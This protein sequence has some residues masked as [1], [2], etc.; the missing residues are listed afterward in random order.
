MYKI[1]TNIKY[2][3]YSQDI[4]ICLVAPD[5]PHCL[6]HFVTY[7]L[8]LAHHL[9]PQLAPLLGGGAALGHPFHIALLLKR[10]RALIH[11]LLAA[12]PLLAHSLVESLAACQVPALLLL[13]L[14]ALLLLYSDT[15]H[16]GFRSTNLFVFTNIN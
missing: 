4:F 5:L 6:R 9:A 10:L 8:C 11:K 15:L 3:I 7:W 1:F 13:H 16:S 14:L 2:R 12:P